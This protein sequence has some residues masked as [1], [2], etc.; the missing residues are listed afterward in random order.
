MGNIPDS[1]CRIPQTPLEKIRNQGRQNANL[2]HWT[3][4]LIQEAAQLQGKV[5]PPSQL[6]VLK[7]AEWPRDS[8][9]HLPLE[10]WVQVS[11]SE[12]VVP[13]QAFRKI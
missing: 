10:G 3:Q 12:G 11:H 6:E 5:G 7:A 9:S 1:T 4:P 8:V 2:R 13:S